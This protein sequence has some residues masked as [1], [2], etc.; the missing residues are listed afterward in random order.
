M[1]D[2]DQLEQVH[3]LEREAMEL[4]RQSGDIRGCSVFGWQEVP[5]LEGGISKG[6]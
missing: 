3:I 2:L 5:A 4:L 6:F 1:N